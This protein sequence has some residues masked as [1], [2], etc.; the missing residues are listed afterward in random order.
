MADYIGR[1]LGNYKI[2]RLL[3]E[4]AFAQVYLGEHI[5]LGTQAAIK[6]LHA[7]LANEPLEWFRTEA[8]TI[9]HL[10][11]PNIVRVLEFGIEGNA[12]FLVLEYAPQGTLRQRHAKGEVVSP[13][14]VV[15]YIKQVAEAL[16]YAHDEKF[17]H[18]DVKPENILL[19][20]RNEVL[21]GDFG[22]ALLL[23]T[24][25][26]QPLQNMAG[27]VAYMAPEQ[28]QGQPG[29]ASDQYA[30]GIIV[31]EWL[32]GERPFEGSPTEVLSQH[33][34][35]SPIP[36][37]RKLPTITPAVEQVVMKALEKDPRRRFPAIRQ[38]AQAL[39]QAHQSS[40]LPSER[41]NMGT[42]VSAPPS[43]F[44]RPAPP[45]AG[46]V[47]PPTPVLP[48]S[49]NAGPVTP[50]ALPSVQAMPQGGSAGILVSRYT[51]HRNVVH[52]LSWSSDGVRIA[53]A[54]HEKTVH[55][56][57]APTGRRLPL[58]KDQSY[59]V[60]LVA[61]S[62]EG[63]R[64]ATVGNDA[65][66]RIWDVATDRLLA[67]Y[68]GH[69][70]STINAIAWAPS[71][72]LLAS[73][74]TDGT[75]HVWD[76]TTGNP[77]IIYRGHVGSVNTLAWSSDAFSSTGPRIVS[78][79]DDR[80]VQTWEALTGRTIMRYQGQPA[81]VL[82]VAW[83]PT[84]YSPSLGYSFSSNTPNVPSSSR[85]A[86]GRDDGFIQMWDT[87]SGREVLSYRYQAPLTTVTWSQDGRRFAYA[88]EDQQ[89]EVWD[90][91]TNRKVFVFSHTAPV[92]VMAWSPD[93]KH[94]ASG[95]GDATIQVWV[96]P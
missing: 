65:Q 3:G 29:P 62:P 7:Q 10:A 12:P 78:G 32:T 84:V 56:W 55:I 31:Y 61:W 63:S 27:T 82:S 17:I 8:R 41:L 14:V 33:L 30:L 51:G 38:F 94:I 15:S 43:G 54:S 93:G 24:F 18:R 44:E 71:R 70:G 47:I 40:I 50:S 4:G 91:M 59:V 90:T 45:L 46:N 28:I 23:Q 83:S 34:A 69:G 87:I 48:Q 74:A 89:I 85:I 53:S 67:R 49:A 75:V 20:R 26:D 88:S 42:G 35:V 80:S 13:S 76:A 11:H 68:T 22:I 6:V 72:P 57:E 95:G 16:Q 19:G 77:L 2:V 52:S 9:A 37:R 86:C 36:L 81:R 5:Y 73:A 1:Q 58:Y 25:K 21:L 79:G 39:E 96:A 92:R 60:S 64:L 66:V